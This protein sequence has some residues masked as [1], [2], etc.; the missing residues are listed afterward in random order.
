[1]DGWERGTE[2]AEIVAPFP[3]K[4]AITSLGNSVATADSGIEAEVV[5]FETLAALQAADMDSLTGKIAYVGH[6]MQRTQDG[7]SYGHLCVSVLQVQLRRQSGCGCN[8]DS[9][10]R[11]R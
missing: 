9:L 7:S 1:M 4:L 5:L 3:Q 11:Y 10:Y 2:V 6:G 8:T